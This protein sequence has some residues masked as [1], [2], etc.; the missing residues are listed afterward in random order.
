MIVE[1]EIRDAI[2]RAD[3]QF[4]QRGGEF[5]A[6]FAELRVGKLAVSGNDP[7]FGAE[8]IDGAVQAA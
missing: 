2:A 5:L 8:Q 4:R 7:D 1:A 3:A 6:A